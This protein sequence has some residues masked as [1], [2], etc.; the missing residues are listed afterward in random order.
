MLRIS[1]LAFAILA[2]GCSSIRYHVSTEKV[3]HASSPA[4]NIS[5]HCSPEDKED[6][7][8]FTYLYLIGK[9]RVD[10]FYFRRPWPYESCL[11]RKTEINKVLKS[12]GTIRI[13]GTDRSIDVKPVFEPDDQG[14]IPKNIDSKAQYHWIFDRIEAGKSCHG[15][16]ESSCKGK[17]LERL[18]KGWTIES[19]PS[20]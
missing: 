6:K 12:A 7:N 3:F 9:D 2:A 15:Y 4:K 16:F 10:H 1:L 20:L 18:G 13:T 11:Y 8:S 14:T 19:G 17:P 5:V